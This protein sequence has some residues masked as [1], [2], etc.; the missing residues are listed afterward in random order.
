MDIVIMF[1]HFVSVHAVDMVV[2]YIKLC[3]VC[4][5]L[6]GIIVGYDWMKYR[7]QMYP[8]GTDVRRWT[9][10]HVDVGEDGDDH[11]SHPYYHN[12]THILN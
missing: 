7:D 10:A 2:G 1:A 12:D 8:V 6:F 3:L 5:A 9:G 4:L 11:A